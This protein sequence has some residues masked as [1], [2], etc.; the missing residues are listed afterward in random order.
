MKDRMY[1]ANANRAETGEMI[2]PDNFSPN[3]KN[4]IIASFF[5]NIGLADELGSGVRNIHHY[6]KL[7]SGKMPQMIDGDVFRIIVPLDDSYSFDARIGGSA[8]TAVSPGENPEVS[9][10]NRRILPDTAG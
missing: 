9:G 3:P 4:P 1:T 8:S 10:E 2:T 6:G 7:Y 5:R